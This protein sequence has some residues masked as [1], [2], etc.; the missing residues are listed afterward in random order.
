MKPANKGYELDAYKAVVGTGEIRDIRRL[1]GFLRGR[2]VVHLNST[3]AGG[4]VAE[5]LSRLLPLFQEVGVDV[6]WEVL[7]GNPEFFEVTK[8]IHNA[9][10]GE[11]VPIDGRMLSLYREV[12]EANR[13][14]TDSESDIVVL[15]DPQPVGLAGFRNGG[16]PQ[17]VWRCHIDVSRADPAVWRF[18]QGYLDKCDAAVY[19]LGDYARNLPI[20]EYVVPPAIDPFSH[21][22][23]EL[24]EEEIESV[25]AQFGIDR[26]RPVVVQV[27]RFDRLKDPV[28]VIDAYRMVRRYMDCQLVLAGGTA[29]DDP[30]GV[31]VLEEVYERRNEDR[32]IHVLNLPPDS[33][34]KINA[35]Q[36]GANV[37]VQ[38]SLREGF[39]LVVTEAMWKGKPVIGGNV[40][41]IRRQ[42]L[43]DITGYRV[44]TVEGLSWR[45]R[46]L[47]GDPEKA[48]KMGKMGR[49]MV[50]QNFLLPGLLQELAARVSLPQP[51]A[52]APGAPGLSSGFLDCRAPL[53]G[54]SLE[55]RRPSVSGVLRRPTICIRGP[56]ESPLQRA[57][58]ALRPGVLRLV[59]R[60]ALLSSS[61]PASAG[62]SVA[63]PRARLPEPGSPFKT[64]AR[65]TALN[66][67]EDGCCP[68]AP[69]SRPARIVGRHGTVLI[70]VLPF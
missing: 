63:W 21:K 34:R 7:D 49:E 56:V 59:G 31:R 58:F 20:N 42:I 28:G 51:H 68:A 47:L 54:E 9:L 48:R 13:G 50:R 12:M 16:T 36:R 22:N 24:P 10:H 43:D 17:M 69:A 33:H 3:K 61:Q 35:L 19:H 60:P 14:K 46:E 52:R 67:P 57:W 62:F 38:K 18:L 32:D 1:A 39:G 64:G 6:C 26:E 27:S 2:R 44:H 65:A 53:W 29:I 23:C 25:F 8:S 41:G 37:V 45:L 70:S 55:G 15:H 4:G 30:E 11:H 66:Q 40:G 5:I